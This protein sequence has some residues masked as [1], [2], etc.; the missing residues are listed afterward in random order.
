QDDHGR[1]ME[2]LGG[3]LFDLA[4]KQQPLVLL[5]D[6]AQTLAD[7]ALEE[8]RLMSSF[9]TAT[10]KLIQIVIVG[11]P[12]L[13]ERLQQPSLAPLRQRIVLAKHLRPLDLNETASYILHRLQVAA[14]DPD[15]PRVAFNHQAIYRIYQISGGIP[16]MINAVCDNA[17][18]LG[19]V[20]KQRIIDDSVINQVS[21][22]MICDL[23]EPVES[24]VTA[25]LKFTARA[26]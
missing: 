2:R 15:R 12:E 24:G 4:R 19:Y 22:D 11:Q 6:E 21:R 1:L 25:P 5:V 10:Q 18:L 9:D 3:H 26:A 20:N 13:R 8:L 23:N 17:M 7:H 16:R 14:T